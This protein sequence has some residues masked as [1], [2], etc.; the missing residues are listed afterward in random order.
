MR[1]RHVPLRV[2]DR[3]ELDQRKRDYEERTGD[4]GDWG[5]FLEVVTLAGMAALGIYSVAQVGRL[6]S[7]IWKVRCPSCGV[8]FPVKAPSPPPWRLSRVTCVKCGTELVLDFV[9][10]SDNVGDTPNHGPVVLRCHYCE[11]EVDPSATAVNPHKVEYL[12]C[13]RCDRVVRLLL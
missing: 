9:K 11:Q 8:R 13:P 12:T 5:R 1:Q 7:V 6:D 4:A 2:D 10:A 3:L